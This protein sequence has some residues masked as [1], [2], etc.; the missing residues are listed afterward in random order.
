M[1]K[2]KW[3]LILELNYSIHSSLG[4][5]GENGLWCQVFS[6]AIDLMRLTIADQVSLLS[7]WDNYNVIQIIFGELPI[8]FALYK[9]DKWMKFS[10]IVLS[11]GFSVKVVFSNLQSHSMPVCFCFIFLFVF[12]VCVFV[13]SC[14][15]CFVSLFAC[16]LNL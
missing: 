15:F 10:V 4:S 14:L 11:A 16:C 3:V 5:Y 6:W 9:H 1:W 13:C 8:E 2:S 12:F 7:Q